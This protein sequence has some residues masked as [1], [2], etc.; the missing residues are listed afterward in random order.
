MIKDSVEKKLKNLLGEAVK[1]LVLLAPYTTL[2]IGGPADYFYEAKSQEDLIRGVAAA[3]SLHLPLFILG[4]GSNILIGDGGFRGLVMKNMARGITIKGAQ[5]SM[6]SG[7]KESIVYVQA[8]SGVNF[9]QLVRFTVEE[10]LAGVER[11]PC[12]PGP[13]RGG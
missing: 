2:K 7:K 12:L 1:T 6:Q 4:G 5:G 11:T 13:V 10:G 8:E 9:N 3:R